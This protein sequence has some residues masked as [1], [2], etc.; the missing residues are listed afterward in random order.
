[1][2]IIGDSD[3]GPHGHTQ[4]RRQEE[5]KL[6]KEKSVYI[7]FIIWSIV[8]HLEKVYNQSINEAHGLICSL[9]SPFI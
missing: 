3:E 4:R 6:S 7:S 8:S 5:I 2:D 1:M 9:S